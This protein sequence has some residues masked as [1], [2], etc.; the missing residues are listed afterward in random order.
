MSQQINLLPT[1]PRKSALSAT[2]ANAMLYGVLGVAALAAVLAVYEN[3]RLRTV[4]SEAQAVERK[5]KDARAAH[6]KAVAALKARKPEPAQDAQLAELEA[7]FKSRQDVV[8]AL[9]SGVLGTTAGFS[10]YMLALSR[11]SMTGVWLTA[12]DI[13]AGGNELTLSGRALSADLV[14][15]YLQRLT[16]EAPLQG[17][18]FASMVISQPARS[19]SG[20]TDAAAEGK[21]QT[22]PG[23]SYI[24]FRISSGLAEA[25]NAQFSA[26]LIESPPPASLA[27]PALKPE[28]AK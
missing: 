11:Q 21:A 2:S 24:E 12:F 9:R 7:Q 15:A 27:S 22:R 28:A 20:R 25:G 6:E 13:G 8:E 14:P 18:R 19:D 23:P 17:R 1:A 26:P 4:Q 3:Y 5:L 10:Q 16:Q